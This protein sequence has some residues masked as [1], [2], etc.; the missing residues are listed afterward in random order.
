MGNQILRL[1]KACVLIYRPSKTLIRLDKCT[2]CSKSWLHTKV[3][4]L[5]LSCI[6]IMLHQM[7]IAASMSHVMRKPDFCICEKKA[8]ISFMVTVKL[9]SAFVFATWIV[10]SLYFVN[11]KFLASSHLLWLHSPVCVRPGRN[12]ERQAFSQRGHM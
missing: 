3:I 4:P 8:Q 2:G 7:F 12:P 1:K 11:Q 9:I 5:V 6:P 10:Q